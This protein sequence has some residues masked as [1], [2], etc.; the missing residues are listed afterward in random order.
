[1]V[2]NADAS[3]K[4]MNFMAEVRKKPIMYPRISSLMKK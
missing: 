3:V 2:N 1:M 4:I